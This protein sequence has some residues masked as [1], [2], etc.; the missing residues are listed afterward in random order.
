M[1]VKVKICGINSDAALDAAIRHGADFVGLVH[2]PKSPRHIDLDFAARL[3]VDARTKSKVRIVVLLVDPDDRKLKQVRDHVKPDIIQL[4]GHEGAD[5]LGEVRAM[6]GLTVMKAVSVTSRDDIA[7]A[8][9]YIAPG[10]ADMLLFDAKP[11]TGPDALPGGNGL[12]FDWHI[13]DAW[14][15][16]KPF[17]LAGGLTPSNVAAAV[18]LT[19]AAMVDVS[20]GVESAPG[21]KDEALIR[22][23]IANA[24]AAKQGA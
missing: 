18:R 13:L 10:K 20:S 23:F 9:V 19:N 21:Q 14:D 7:N 16:T 3:V 11:P 22:L 24:K 1:P 8:A 6:T 15:A 5:R 4:H 2:F 17:M 12:S